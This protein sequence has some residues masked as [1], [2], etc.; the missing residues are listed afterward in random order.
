MTNGE[1]YQN[2]IL[3]YIEERHDVLFAIERNGNFSNCNPCKCPNCIFYQESGKG[4]TCASVKMK[5]FLSEY[6]EPIKLTRVEYEILK[7]SEKEGYKYI[8]RDEDGELCAFQSEP[9]KLNIAWDCC[10]VYTELPLF[11]KLFQFIQWEDKKA[12]SIQEVLNNCE[13]VD[14]DL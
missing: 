6:R 1:K 9:E 4:F 12:T 11:N 7:W 3:E 2:E 13:V 14:S 10:N 8:V 5:W